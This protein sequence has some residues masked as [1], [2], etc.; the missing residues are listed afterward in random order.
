MEVG[1]LPISISMEGAGRMWIVLTGDACK[2]GMYESRC[3]EL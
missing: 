2:V 3:H 1:G